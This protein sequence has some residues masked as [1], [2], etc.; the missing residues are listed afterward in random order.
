M[1]W[2]ATGSVTTPAGFE[3][4]AAACGLKGSGGL[5]L[6]LIV[7]RDECSAAGVFTRNQVQAAPVLLDREVLASNPAGIRGVVANSGFANA[8]T[9]PAGLQAA[10]AMQRL[11]AEALGCRPEQVLVL[12]TGIIGP[13]PDLEKVARGVQQAA[14]NLSP[15]GGPAAARAIMTTDTRP[16]SRALRI[17]LPA[18]TVTLGGVAKGAGMIHPDMA[19]MLAVLTTDARLAAPLLQAS[20][21]RAVANS[22]NRI[23]VD[24]DTS[25]NDTVL[26]LADGAS[27]AAV[28]G[29]QAIA[30]FDQG[31]L[32]LCTALA[33]DIVRDGE[34]ASKFVTITVSGARREAEA[35][36]IARTIATSPLVKTAFAGGDPNWGRVLAAAGRA[37][38][39]LDPSRLAL[40]IGAGAQADLP[41]VVRG[42]PVAYDPLAAA[43]IFARDEFCIH[44][45]LGLG[46]DT[47]TAWTCDLTHEYVTINAEYHT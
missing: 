46:E 28:E 6:A 27:G 14:Q 8:C 2:I 3:A 42:A 13:L 20:L 4:A 5:D 16:K 7:A 21:T 35:L 11:A 19:T 12:S 36:Q 37:G 30:A 15:Q 29:E 9:G 25:T 26:L 10:R 33:Q 34:G 44:L 24:G 39:S 22:F 45:D 23:S 40:R 38:V 17:E 31:L 1:E 47:A 43:A 18:G 32:A 41:I